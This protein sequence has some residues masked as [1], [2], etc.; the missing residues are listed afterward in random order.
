MHDSHYIERKSAFSPC[1]Q[2][3]PDTFLD[4]VYMWLQ[5]LAERIEAR[6]ARLWRRAGRMGR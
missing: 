5:R 2:P 3:R 1:Y 4:C 6:A